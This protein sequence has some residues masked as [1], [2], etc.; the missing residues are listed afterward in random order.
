M[1]KS[2]DPDQTPRLAAS[3]LGLHCLLRPVSPNIKGLLRYG[4]SCPEI[5]CKTLVLKK[6]KTFCPTFGHLK[7]SNAMT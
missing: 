4:S 5:K 2:V 7:L 3:D 6:T 1:A